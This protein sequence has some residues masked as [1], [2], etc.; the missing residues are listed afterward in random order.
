MLNNLLR[1]EQKLIRLI[2][3][4]LLIKLQRSVSR[5]RDHQGALFKLLINAAGS[6]INKYCQINRIKVISIY[7]SGPEENMSNYR[8]ISLL[9]VSSKV[10]LFEKL[11][12]SR[13]FHSL[14]K[15]NIVS[16]T[17]YGFCPNISPELAVLDVV[18]S[19]NRI[20]KNQFVGLIM[21]D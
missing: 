4:H 19:C 17:Q 18:S 15:H 14:K 20:S 9:P 8:P 2:W 3:Q 21:L 13:I 10:G 11:I 12:Y 16:S 6:F 1:L 5:L 7:K